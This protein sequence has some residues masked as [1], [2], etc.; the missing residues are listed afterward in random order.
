MCI[1]EVG[2]P[3]EALKTPRLVCFGQSSHFLGVAS[4]SSYGSIDLGIFKPTLK[5]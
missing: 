1:A 5:I 4:R 3:I 2:L